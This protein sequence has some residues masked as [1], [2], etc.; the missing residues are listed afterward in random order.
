MKYPAE[1]THLVFNI[2]DKQTACGL[3][4][5]GRALTICYILIE[6]KNCKAAVIRKERNK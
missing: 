5:K 6:C 4:S 3:T 1:V 2:G